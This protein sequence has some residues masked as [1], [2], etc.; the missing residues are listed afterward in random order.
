MHAES[1][2]SGLGPINSFLEQKHRLEYI[3]EGCLVLG[4]EVGAGYGQLHNHN[5]KGRRVRQIY[6]TSYGGLWRTQCKHH[7][8]IPLSAARMLARQENVIKRSLTTQRS[9]FLFILSLREN[10]CFYLLLFFRS[11]TVFAVPSVSRKKGSCC[12][13]TADRVLLISNC[14]PGDRG[15]LND[16][17]SPVSPFPRLGHTLAIFIRIQ[18]MASRVASARFQGAH[19]GRRPAPLAACHAV[20]LDVSVQGAQG[21]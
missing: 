8:H 13:Y 10:V 7:A 6:R 14:R 21:G 3:I 20:M 9:S 4:S 1:V 18:N 15:W 19:R 17:V 2:G 16:S 11:L 5:V 12:K